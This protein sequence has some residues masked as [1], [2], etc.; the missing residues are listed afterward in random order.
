M[1]IKKGDKV[2][3]ITGAYK[4]TIA[5]VTKV[6]PKE[7][8]VIV[9]GV[10]LVK[11]HMKPTQANPDGGIVEMEAPIHVSNVM[12]YDSKAKKASRVGFKIADGKKVR[13]YKATGAE[14]K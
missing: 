3:V 5:E 9:E 10:N 2:Q 7:S 8:K 11:K 14:V 4:G 1:K 13:V 12:L 6:L